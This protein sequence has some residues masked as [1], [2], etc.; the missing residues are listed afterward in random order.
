MGLVCQVSG[1]TGVAS[2]RRVW[3][4]IWSLG[5]LFGVKRKEEK[6]GAGARDERKGWSKRKQEEPAEEHIYCSS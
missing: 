3:G 6:G 5:V 1:R 2:G 4:V